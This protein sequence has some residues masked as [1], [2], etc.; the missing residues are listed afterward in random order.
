MECSAKCAQYILLHLGSTENTSNASTHWRHHIRCVGR[1]HTRHDI[2]I[3]WMTMH[4]VNDREKWPR[5]YQ[6]NDHNAVALH[7]LLMTTLYQRP[8]ITVLLS[9]HV[10]RSQ[11][12]ALLE[13]R[14]VVRTHAPDLGTPFSKSA[15]S[16]SCLNNSVSCNSPTFHVFINFSVIRLLQSYSTK[17]CVENATEVAT[18]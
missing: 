7:A 17:A 8:V 14:C 6:E 9:L 1:C 3:S 16:F 2:A 4:D 10:P 5:C 13:S 18:I 12:V 15:F 11:W